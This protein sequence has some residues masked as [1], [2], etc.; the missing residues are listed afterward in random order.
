MHARLQGERRAFEEA[1]KR[2]SW[3][4]V[5]VN[6]KTHS[7]TQKLLKQKTVKKIDDST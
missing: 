6:S 4:E 5:K 1:G 7:F 2:V 3:K